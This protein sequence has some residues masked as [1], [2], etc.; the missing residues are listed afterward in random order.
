[1]TRKWWAHHSSKKKTS[2]ET[3]N[4]FRNGWILHFNLTIEKKRNSHETTWT[5]ILA[6]CFPASQ[7]KKEIPPHKR[8]S[9]S[10]SS[11]TWKSSEIASLAVKKRSKDS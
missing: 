5:E 7:W 9:C 11:L 4:F 6:D 8:N 2:P 1:M 3:L 10:S